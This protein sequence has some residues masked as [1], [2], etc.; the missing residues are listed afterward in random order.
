MFLNSL[1]NRHESERGAAMVAVLGVTAVTALV[2]ITVTASTINALGTTSSNKASVQARA[3]AEA[4][5]DVAVVGMSTTDGCA[6]EGGTFDSTVAPRYSAAVSYTTDDGA[7]WSTGCPPDTA[8]HIQISSTGFAAS[9]GVAGHDRGDSV[10][11]EAIYTWIPIYVEV[12][13]IEPA[14][15][16]HTMEGV[17]KN[18]VLSSATESI[19]ADVQIKNG[20][21][22][23]E[24]GARIDG[25]VILG[26]GYVKLNRCDVDGDIHVSQW[27]EMAGNNT[28]VNGDII[29]LGQG[30]STGNKVVKI[31]G[32]VDKV[33][34]SVYAG[35]DIEVDDRVDG[36]V[37]LVGTVANKVEVDGSVGGSVISSGG[38]DIKGTVGGSVSTNVSGMAALPVPRVPDWTDIPYPTSSWD[39]Y[40]EVMWS[41]NCNIGNSHSFWNQLANQT[42]TTGNIVVNALSCGA[43][44]LNFQN[45]IKDMVLNANIVFV[46]WAFNVDKLDVISNNVTPRDLWF[47][48]PDNTADQQP[49]CSGLAGN[50]YLTNEADFHHTV[51]ALVY[52]PCKI[53]SDRNHWRGQF[54][55]GTVE[56]LQ[57]AIMTYEQVGVPGVDFDSSLPPILA[58]DDAKLGSLVSVREAG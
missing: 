18:F 58:L 55:G 51:S 20:N 52:T 46:A 15:Y 48:V 23:C 33:V 44:G 57:Q 17:F 24:N 56:F 32:G 45:N 16:A 27:V 42:A 5:L 19:A 4:G 10:T 39:A 53:K 9:P 1:L 7:N 37:T 11:L 36:S 14:V 34:G 26:N 13:Q 25:S 6:L 31:A 47:M 43:A 40:T 50:I 35:G 2:G 28:L 38:A 49:T 12:P 21:V 54:Y 29:A 22:I 3:A 41:G 8:T 30:V